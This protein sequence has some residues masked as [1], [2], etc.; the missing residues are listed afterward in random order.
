[1]DL[2]LKVARAGRDDD[3]LVRHDGR[4]QVGERLAGAGPRLDHQRAALLQ[5]LRYG[6][7]HLLLAGPVL[8]TGVSPGKIAAGPEEA[9]RQLQ[10]S[11]CA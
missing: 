9:V 11:R 3:P 10:S 5:Q 8:V 1:M 6:E 2:I 4:H 7:R